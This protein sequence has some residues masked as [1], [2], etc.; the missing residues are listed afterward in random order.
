MSVI[1]ALLS[2]ACVLAAV[3]HSYAKEWHG[4]VPLHST[5]SDV[6]RL[7]GPPRDPSKEHASIHNLEKEVVFIVYATGPPCGTDGTS[8]W[9]VPRGTVIGITLSP[10][11]E[12]R[13]SDLHIDESKYK[14]TDGNGHVPGIRYYTDETEG[15]Q[16]VV[17]R[18]NIVDIT[19]FHS[20]KDNH[21]RCPTP[22]AKPWCNKS[23]SLSALFVLTDES[24]NK[25]DDL[26]LLPTRQA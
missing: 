10:K 19:Y 5:R 22:T 20:A 3:S 7:L 9:Q 21:L 12:L 24:G 13:F 16:F 6:E 4:I 14:I 18:G 11:A 25:L 26:F 15:L 1:K 8:M 23:R 2:C 17:T